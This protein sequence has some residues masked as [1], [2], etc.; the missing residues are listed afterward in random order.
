MKLRSFVLATAGS[1]ALFLG[2]LTAFAA[3]QVTR[4]E[5]DLDWLEHTHS[6]LDQLEQSRLELKAAE[7]EFRSYRA[8]GGEAPRERARQAAEAVRWASE[9]LEKLTADNPSQSARA[10][11]LAAAS[12]EIRAS[13]E[14]RARGSA[15]G[16]AAALRAE[17]TARAMEVAERLLLTERSRR[18]QKSSAFALGALTASVLCALLLT[19]GAMIFVLRGLDDREKLNE[20]LRQAVALTRALPDHR[21]P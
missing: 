9:A 11:D 2:A 15:D 16:E 13:V 10:Q 18:E 8:G 1:T 7:L 4:H 19:G 17:D 14:N 21:R 5:A 20:T 6:V 12:A 3:Y